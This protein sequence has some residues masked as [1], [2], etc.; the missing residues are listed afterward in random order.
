VVEK[1][2]TDK[3]PVKNLSRILV[4]LRELKLEEDIERNHLAYTSPAILADSRP[5]RSL[6]SIA[7]QLECCLVVN[8]DS[9]GLLQL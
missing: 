2:I 8:E 1:C 6:A 3:N 9:K 4:Y 5:V 7:K